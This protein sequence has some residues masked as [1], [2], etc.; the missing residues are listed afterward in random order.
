LRA[1]GLTADKA[2]PLGV[3]LAGMRERIGQIGGTFSVESTGAGTR[4]RTI[5][6]IRPARDPTASTPASTE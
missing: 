5:I 1:Y 4:V 6:A 3:G 2:P